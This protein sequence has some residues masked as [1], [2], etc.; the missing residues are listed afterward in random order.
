[1]QLTVEAPDASGHRRFGVHAQDEEGDTGWTLHAEGVLTP[2]P[3]DDAFTLAAWP[4]PDATPVDLTGLYEGL[5]D[6]GYGYGPAFQGLRAAWRL[7]DE[8]FAEVALPDDVDTAGFGLHPALLDAALHTTHTDDPASGLRL[9]FSWTGVS[10]AASGATRLR[11][12]LTRLGDDAVSLRLADPTGAPVASVA[13]LVLRGG[14]ARQRPGAAGTARTPLYEVN[15][16]PVPAPAVDGDPAAPGEAAD[17]AQLDTLAASGAVPDVV[18]VPCPPVEGP[19]AEATRTVTHRALALLRHWVSDERFAASRLVFV[20]SGAMAAAPGDVVR[21]LPHAALWGL[22]RSAQTEHPDRFLLVDVPSGTDPRTGDARQS[23]AAALATGEPQLALRDGVVLVPRLARAPHQDAEPVRLDPRGTVLVTG[24]TGALGRVVTRHLVTAYGARHLLLVGRRGTAAPGATE[25]LAELEELGADVTLAACDTADRDAV[26]G[27]LAGIPAAHPLTAVVHSAGV[28]DDSVVDTLTPERVDTVL[29]PKVDAAVNLHELTEGTPLDAFVVFSS[30]AG[31]LGGAGQAN[32]AA[33]NVFLDALAQR[34]RA[35]GLP[36]TSIAWGLWAEHSGLA[37]TLADT[38]I[39]RLG[40]SGIAPLATEDGLA[41]F[42]AAVADGSRAAVVAARIDTT[43]LRA[44]GH[45]TVPAVLRGLVRTPV[46]RTANAGDSSLAQRLRALP[47]G[48]RARTVRDLVATEAAAVLGRSP[49]GEAEVD[50]AFEELGFDSLTVVELR[51]RLTAATGLRLPA[52]VAFDHPNVAALAAHI[53]DGLIG[54]E[55]P[56][57]VPAPRRAPASADD[58]PIAIVA[59]SCRYPGGVGSPEDLWRLVHDGTDAITE[60]PTDRGWDLGSLFADDP[61]TPGTS[62]ARHGGF[63]DAPGDFDAAFFGMSPREALATDPQQRLLLE[64]AWEAFERAGIDP[65]SLRGSRTGVFAGLMHHDYVSRL[66]HVPQELEGYVSTGTA[67]SVASG[68]VSYVFGFEGPTLTVDTAC[69]SSLVTLHLAAQALRQGECDLALAGGVTVLASPETFVEFSRQRG[70]SPD[71]RCRAYAEGANGVGWAEGAGVLL[72]ERLSDAVRN[73][74]RVLAVVRGS[75]VNS[76]GASNGLTAPNGPSQQR[77]IRDALAGAGLV[78]ADVDVVEGHGTGTTLGDPIE[79]QALLAT[80][81][82]D[83]VEPVLLG[84]LKSNIG[85]AQ[86]AAGVGGVIKMV[87]AMRAGVVPRTLHVDAPSSHVDW[88]AGEVRLVTENVA[89]PD[90]GRVRRSA[91]SS[92]GISGTNAHVV[93]EQAPQN[94][95]VPRSAGTRDGSVPAAVVP[96]VVSA[97][98]E[99]ALEARLAGVGSVVGSRVDVG[100]S[101][102]GC[103]VFGH[104]AVVLA[105]DGGVVE[106]ARGVAGGVGRVGVLFSGQGAQRLGMGRGLYARFGVFARA[107]DEVVEHFDGLREVVWGADEGVLNRTGWAQPAL[108]AVEVALFRLVEWLGV[109]VEVVG[110]HSIGEVAAAHVAGVLSLED[111]CA[112]VSARAR[113]ME[114]LPE[115]GAMVA[116]GAEESEVLPLLTPGVSVAAVNG[117]GAVVVAGVEEEVAA[118]VARLEGR[119]ATRLRVSHAFHSPLME[120]MLAEFRRV[121]EGLEFHE[122]GIALVSNVTG[123]LASGD[124][125]R[126]PGYWVRH[127]REAVRFADGVGALAEAGVDTFL[128]LGPDGVLSGLVGR[129]VPE[130]SAVPVLRKGRD[131]ESAL[132]TALGRLFTAGVP[133]DWRPL[134]EGTGATGVDLPTYPFQRERYWLE[135]ATTRTTDVRSAGL[136]STG[137]AMLGAAVPLAGTGGQV[138]TARLSAR[139]HPWLA[140]HVVA[141]AVPVPGAA[142]VECVLRAGDEVG[143]GTLQELT[144]TAPVVLPEDGDLQLQISLDAADDDGRF[145]VAVHARTDALGEW[146]LHAEGLLAPDPSDADAGQLVTWPP[147]GSEAVDVTGLYERLA[148]AGLRYGPLFRGIRAAWRSGDE[149]FTEIEPET[150][151][152]ITGFALHPALFDAAV[153]SAALAGD[154]A[155]PKLPFTWSGVTLHAREAAAL[156]VRVTRTGTDTFSLLATDPDGDPVLTVDSLLVRPLAGTRA[157]TPEHLYR[158]E[159]VE[160]AVPGGASEAGGWAVAGDDPLG[161]T[162]GLGDA[163]ARFPDLTALGAALDAGGALPAVVCVPLPASGDAR[164]A[165]VR[166]LETVRSWLTDGRYTDAKL[167]FLTRGAVLDPY[168]AD[169]PDRLTAA[170]ARG[171]VRSAQAEHPGRFLLLDLDPDAVT[172]DA[173]TLAG[174]PA[175]DEPQLALRGGTV[176][177]QRLVRARS[178]ASA[179]PEWGDSVLVTGGTGTLGGLVARHLVTAHGVRRLVLAGRR[180]PDAPGAAALVDELTALGAEVTAVAVDLTD[181]AAVAALLAEHPVTGVVHAAGVVADATVESLTPDDIATVFR[182]KAD[183][184]VHLDELTRDRDLRA[185]VLFS[186]IAGVLGTPGQGNYAAANAFL[187]ALAERRRAAGL[188]ATSVAWGLWEESSGMTA[189]LAAQDRRRMSGSGVLPLPTAQGLAL[190]DEAAASDEPVLAAVRLDRS[191]LRARADDGTLPAQLRGLAPARTRRAA[192]GQGRS[193]GSEPALARRLRTLP[194][195]QRAQAAVTAVIAETAAVLGHTGRDA[196]KAGRDFKDLGF[197]SLTAVELRNRLDAATGLRLP[198]SLVFDHPSPRAVAEYLLGR[199]EPAE[200][201]RSPSPTYARRSPGYRWSG[202]GRPESWTACSNSPAGPRPAPPPSPAAAPASARRT[203]PVPAPPTTR[204]TPWTPTTWWPWPSGTTP[205]ALSLKR[206]EH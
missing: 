41:L 49:I 103:S 195:A 87:M 170:A 187:D 42:D 99:G 109:R 203:R 14:D 198:A 174:V 75:A 54:T 8:V 24:A 135:P 6:R 130:A 18:L 63:L 206:M 134:F 142:L 40:R 82:R 7:G 180:G 83:R 12:R 25:L 146:T 50:R 61:E 16:R 176:L 138:F 33:A 67:G 51:H 68:R 81:G 129:I 89:W 166:T 79:A 169:G 194:A 164:E 133:V 56:D 46:R 78:A 11:V 151:P 55:N 34:R 202:C 125:V 30:V 95:D 76:D 186:S 48:D 119:K 115:G 80:Y 110:G 104:R 98:S 13:S 2:E 157:R 84:S 91:V 59:M 197:D 120:P 29:R 139:T 28:I 148:E 97:R 150:G 144:I 102:L 199:L 191:T 189:G 137:H 141:G 111:A 22:V 161:V 165:T 190:F 179:A 96:W 57:A 126:D 58:D 143:C 77:V 188:P 153:H 100:W 44:P 101:L 93:L 201:G 117:P 140:E 52:A 69:S 64:I 196:V 155:E 171:L 183:A 10:L 145:P 26:A 123:R 114:A 116:V 154:T 1:M 178:G 62:Y 74:R 175:L 172:P 36:A 132:L 21:D 23:L 127:V 66:G 185:F 5:S 162:E 122:P 107:F 45:G 94:T 167:V 149:V 106:V 156:R 173:A 160:V 184:A 182:P 4:P 32:Y 177:A 86:A 37:A 39:K 72:L 70:L 65:L 19:L 112:L 17:R 92:F 193:Q 204:S 73:G 121:V 15:W 108:F 27:L 113:L 43:A 147:A 131:E 124:L 118:V 3:A 9:P 163:V 31:T 85:H 35:A 168:V 71:G 192:A 53:L 200:P 20:T 158:P 47:E 152:D 136:E 105:S 90:A 205:D 60:F 128:E 181:R 88:S 38:D 159:W